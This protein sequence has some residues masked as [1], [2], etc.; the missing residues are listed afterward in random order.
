[1]MLQECDVYWTYFAMPRTTPSTAM[2][3]VMAI[4]LGMG[5]WIIGTTTYTATNIHDKSDMCCSTFDTGRSRAEQIG[6][7]MALSMSTLLTDSVNAK[8]TFAS[9]FATNGVM[10]T[11]RGNFVGQTAI[12]NAL[13]DYINN[14]GEQNVAVSIRESYWD[15]V[16]S[17]LVKEQQWKATTTASRY[18]LNNVSQIVLYPS[19]TNYTTDD[20]IVIRFDCHFKVVYYRQYF[21]SVQRVSTYTQSYPYV[22]EHCDH[23]HHHP[24]PP[25]T[26][27]I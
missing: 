4:V 11:S 23:H 22:C 25:P 5:I 19:G 1:M 12:K 26:Q 15:Y 24:P 7:S 20:A 27:I 8:N 14:P 3:I 17:T 16:K 10:S 21:D 18:L 6:T 13:Q 9:Y 2:I